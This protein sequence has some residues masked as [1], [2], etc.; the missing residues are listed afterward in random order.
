MVGLPVRGDLERTQDILGVES[1]DGCQC[2]RVFLASVGPL[3]RATIRSGKLLVVAVGSHQRGGL[4]ASD[5]TQGP[6]ARWS[7]ARCT[8]LPRTSGRAQGQECDGGLKNAEIL[9]WFL[10]FVEIGVNELSPANA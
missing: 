7:D 8:S 9:H 1:Q 10:H 6:D 2:P 5:G 3:D 4:V